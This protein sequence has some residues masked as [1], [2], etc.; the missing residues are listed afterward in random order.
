M[1]T[2]FSD[3]TAQVTDDELDAACD[4]IRVLEGDALGKPPATVLDLYRKIVM[5]LDA[6]EATD[7]THAAK[8]AREAL[9]ALGLPA[10]KV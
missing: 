6:P 3:P 2:E 7:M 8:L 5:V 9:A 4:L 1:V 10:N